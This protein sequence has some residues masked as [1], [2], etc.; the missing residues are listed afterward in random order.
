MKNLKEPLVLIILLMG[1]ALV[2]SNCATPTPQVIE[3]VVTKEVPVTVEVTKIV[4]RVVVATPTPESASILNWADSLHAT[5]GGM[6]Y[7]YSAETG[8][9]E[10]ITNIPYDKLPCKKCHTDECKDCHIRAGDA[11]P[12][13]KCLTCHGRQAKEI[14]IEGIA[15][16]HRDEYGL[17]C[18]NCHDEDESHGD[19]N[20]YHSMLEGSIKIKCIDCHPEPGNHR[21]HK[22]HLETVDCSACHVKNVLTCYNCH[23]DSLVEK[24]EKIA[25]KPFFNWKFLVKRNGKVHAAN[26][27]VLAYKGQTFVAIAPFYGHSIVRPDPVKSCEECHDSPLVKEYRE[28]GT[29]TITWWDK[30]EQAIK[31]FQGVI[32]VPPDYEKAFKFAFVTRDSEGNWVFLK[33][34]V[35][36]FQMLFAEP[37]EEMPV[38]FTIED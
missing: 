37:L 31:Y 23:F 24:K 13:K 11:P 35:D 6:A 34:K 17:Q 15:D 19:G 7:W 8:G 28:K 25:Y 12:Q 36:I 22:L 5:T 26:L 38:Q 2:A 18:V 1:L 9:F 29:M 16:L 20:A 3:R 27:M 4:E 14:K 32:P 33:D 30:D 21:A 10:Q